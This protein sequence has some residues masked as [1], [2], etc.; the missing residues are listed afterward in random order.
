MAPPDGADLPIGSEGMPTPAWI[1]P[2]VPSP[3]RMYDYLL[4]GKDNYAADRAAAESVLQAVPHGRAIARANRR[5]LTRA[6]RCMAGQGVSQFIELGA[7]FPARP[8]VH[9]IARTSVPHARV[10]YIDN[11]PVVTV[12]N[13]ALLAGREG[14]EAIHGDIREPHPIFASPELEQLIDFGQPVGLLLVAVLHLIPPEDDPESTIRTFLKY[15][16]PGSYL[17]VSHLCR[18]GTDPE[19]IRAIE[20][21]GQTASAPAVFRTTG[22]I[23]A[24]F[25]GLDLIPPGLADVTAWPG[26]LPAPAQRPAL[27]VLAGLAR[28]P[29]PSVPV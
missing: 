17:A 13:R 19:V 8:A 23:R 25:D 3:A 22:Q 16:A 7:G 10:L 2:A 9:D 15:L 28:R 26:C 29:A 1:N 14:I 11:D 5:F 18:D 24:F 4:G 12:H 27:A 20:H 6:V 21:A